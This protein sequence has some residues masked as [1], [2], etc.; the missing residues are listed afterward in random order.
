MCSRALDLLQKWVP[1]T[2]AIIILDIEPELGKKY[3][4]N[5]L[6]LI[7]REKIVSILKDD[8]EALLKIEILEYL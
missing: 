4:D 8:K 3:Q 7:K 2:Q 1:L 5:Y 6:G